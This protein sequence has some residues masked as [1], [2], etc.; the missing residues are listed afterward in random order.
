VVEIGTGGDAGT[1]ICFHRQGGS[2]FAA[3]AL[4]EV[5]AQL[6]CQQGLPSRL[7]SSH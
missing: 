2:D 1:S 3:E 7:T 4:F 6:F 5:L